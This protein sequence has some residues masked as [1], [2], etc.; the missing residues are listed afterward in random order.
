MSKY[1]K[2]D[3]EKLSTEPFERKAFISEL[4]LENARMKFKIFSNVV[5]SVCTHFSRKYREKSLAC[6]ACSENNSTDSPLPGNN[7][8]EPRDTVEHKL[9]FCNEYN[10]LKEDHFD[11]LNSK[12]LT[13]FFIRVLNRRK[14]AG[15]D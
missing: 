2:L 14:E 5:P 10:D 15:D 12:M 6:P 1:K 11:P 3:V 8:T 7:T 4:S 13:D 9:L